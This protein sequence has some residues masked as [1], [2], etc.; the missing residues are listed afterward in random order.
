M[1]VTCRMYFDAFCL[2]TYFFIILCQNRLDINTCF[3]SAFRIFFF[4]ESFPETS[5]DAE[6]TEKNDAL[7]PAST[8]CTDE[9]YLYEENAEE[10]TVS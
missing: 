8:P 5:N 4:S 6:N 10:R 7:T 3:E 2:P 9:K 1:I